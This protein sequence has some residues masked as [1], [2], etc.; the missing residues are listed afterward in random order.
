MVL[1]VP[2]VLLVSMVLLVPAVFLVSVAVVVLV[3]LVLLVL[4][5]PVVPL[6]SSGSGGSDVASDL[7]GSSGSDGS[8][9]YVNVPNLAHLEPFSTNNGTV[10][11]ANFGIDPK[12]AETK[13]LFRRATDVP[14]LQRMEQ[15]TK[16]AKN[17]IYQLWHI[18]D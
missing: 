5:V 17:I 7:A 6:T 10:W 3:L 14:F 13:L 11:H 4:Q 16:L 15:G 2:T 9:K 12:L 18:S 1:L 8:S